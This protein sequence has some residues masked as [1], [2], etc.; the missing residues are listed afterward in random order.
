MNKNIPY[1]STFIL[2]VLLVI[3]FASS[4]EAQVGPSTSYGA[5]PY[6]SYSG[7]IT[8]SNTNIMSS[9][10]DNGYLITDVIITQTEST[11]GFCG[12]LVLFYADSTP[13]AHFRIASSVDGNSGWGQ[14]LISHTFSSGLPISPGQT[15]S[16]QTQNFSC[17]NI[18]YTISGRYI[19]P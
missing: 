17:S 6:E 9:P 7:D 18:S 14:G 10:S 3:H 12:G 4:G 16:V 2:V 13:I 15:L 19:Q 8:S 11:A 1:A 5:I